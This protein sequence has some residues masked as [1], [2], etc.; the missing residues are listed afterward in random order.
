[1]RQLIES[2]P[3]LA[4]ALKIADEHAT[5][6]AIAHDD[7]IAARLLKLQDDRVEPKDE[8]HVALAADTWVAIVQ[9]VGGASLV[10]SWMALLHLLVRERVKLP[11]AQLVEA[12]QLQ[13]DARPAPALSRRWVWQVQGVAR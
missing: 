6:C 7:R 11:R 9:L 4:K 1:M 12:V 13:R 3:G 10:L 8:V 5:H 2:S